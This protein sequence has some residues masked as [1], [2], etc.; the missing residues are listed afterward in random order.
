LP[1][2]SFTVEVAWE[3]AVSLVFKLDVSTLDSG[4][5][6]DGAGVADFTGAFDN[7]TDD[8]ETIRIKRGRDSHISR[9]VGG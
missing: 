4:S 2:A 6:L 5:V 1:A 9:V 8:V 7:V 3:S